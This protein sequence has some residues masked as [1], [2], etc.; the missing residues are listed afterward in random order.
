MLR[1]E[2]NNYTKIFI[3]ITLF[4]TASCSNKERESLKIATAANMQ[5]AMKEL[6][7]SFHKRTGIKCDII[8][9]SSGKLTAQIK[10]GAPYDI[11]VSAD[12]KFPNELYSTG[13][14]FNKPK[15]YAFGKL[16]LWTL[17]ESLQ[18]NL[19]LLENLTIKHIAVANPKTAPY[20]SA[21]EELLKNEQLYTKIKN[22]FVFG[23]S[24]AQTNQ[25][26]TTMAAEV[27]FTAKSVVFSPQMKGKD[28]WIDLDDNNYTPISQGIV[29]LKNDAIKIESAQKF[30]NFLYSVEGKKILT[31]YGYEVLTE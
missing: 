14:T 10:E 22:K 30:Y 23:E 18:P 28:N 15:V 31:K 4:F 6:T 5:Y 2:F 29:I 7:S 11:F 16:I 3:L 20:G 24:V 12:M 9:S 8:V 19:K 26:I 1:L 25:F 13:F 17:D 21:A 27:G